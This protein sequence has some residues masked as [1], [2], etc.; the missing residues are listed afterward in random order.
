MR[1]ACGLVWSM[2][3]LLFRSRASLEAEILILCHQ[4]DIQRRHLPKRPIFNATDRLISVALYRLLP[5][6]SA[7]RRL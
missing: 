4:L 7:R 5:G 2:L 6:T 3:A 1:D